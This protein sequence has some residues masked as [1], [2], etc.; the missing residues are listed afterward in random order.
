MNPKVHRRELFR[1]A[2]LGASTV[3]SPI[4]FVTPTFWRQ[5]TVRPIVISS[6]NGHYHKNGG[7]QTCVELA[8]SQLTSGT[9]VLEA[10]IAGVNLVELDPE[11][12]SVGY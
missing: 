2:A 3:I 7:T 6:S 8:F 10:L 9:D 1:G 5:Q 4:P 12:N 11:D